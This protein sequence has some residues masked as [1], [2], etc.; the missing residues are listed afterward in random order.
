MPHP[1]KPERKI[2]FASD[3]K[4][5]DANCKDASC[6][7]EPSPAAATMMPNNL[8]ADIK[9]IALAVNKNKKLIKRHI[10]DNSPKHVGVDTAKDIMDA[11]AGWA[12]VVRRT[13]ARETAP[14]PR[15]R[16]TA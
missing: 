8:A 16:W 3:S 5:N 12:H 2:K 10:E 13:K 15:M 11:C 14:L 1:K 4:C 9:H 7:Q 6:K